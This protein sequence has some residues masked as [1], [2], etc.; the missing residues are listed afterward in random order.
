MEKEDRVQLIR[1]ILA[2]VTLILCVIMEHI[3]WFSF[4]EGKW[5]H[6]VPFLIPYLI[7]GY[8][9]ILEAFENIFHGE[10]FEE[11][12][13]MTIATFGAFAIG[14]YPEAAFVM[15]FF[16][17]GELFEDVAVGKSRASIAALM[18]IAPEIAHIE[19]DG[20]TIDTD[21]KEVAAGDIL[22]VMPGEMIPVDSVVTEG[23]SS[24]DTSSLTG[25]SVPVQVR[26]GEKVISGCLNG[27]GL[28][29]VRAEKVYED[30]TVSKVL[31]LVENASERKAVTENFI[32]R[33][34]H[35][36]TPVV[37]AAA[38]LLA[39]LPPL[40]FGGDWGEWIRRACTFLVISCPCAL[41][42][43]VPLGFFGGIGAASKIGVLVKGSNFLE[44]LSEVKT[45][46][47]DKTGT[48]TEGSFSV[49]KLLPAPGVSEE[50]LL[51]LTAAAERYS[52]HPIAAAIREAYG[53]ETDGT[54][55]GGTEEISGQGI[56]TLYDGKTLLAGN[57]KLMKGADIPYILCEENGTAVYTAYDGRYLG[58]ILVGDTVKENA[59]EAILA[60][61]RNGIER[62]VMLTGDRREAAE[63]VAGK[64]PVD[65]VHAELLPDEKVLAL[66]KLLGD[67]KTAF[68]GDGIN[69]APVLMRSDVGIA[70]GSLG[71]D[72][73]I[74]AADIVLMDDDLSKIAKTVK[75]SKKTLRIVRENI[76][77]ALAV[78]FLVLIL[79]AFG[80]A[81]MGLAV[82]ADVGVLVI[83]VLNAMRALK[84]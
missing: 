29:K 28:L 8:D 63:A 31:E 42:V 21:P 15:I 83:A 25:E 62:V 10:L 2:A 71:S 26:P 56:R 76:I 36:Y 4:L 80:I 54:K 57:E 58:C 32:T 3:G 78:K 49:T 23:E 27:S 9:V 55:L 65:E 82:F 17:V 38:V 14:E 16:K 11:D 70:M 69:D 35:F 79:G 50:E 44:A 59:D 66:E 5:Y 1:I 47:C 84:V 12:F 73:A 24:V 72:A 75:I 34:A 20:Q 81:S 19:R 22:I 18:E 52:T 30:S 61:K 37:T 60:M 43:S 45:L 77:F 51:L 48:L 74:E 64:L 68:V 33:F 53:Q 67:R 41:V 46:V 13:L 39:V 40:V 6:F 7:A